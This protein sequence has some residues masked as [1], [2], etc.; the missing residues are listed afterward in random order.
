[1]TIQAKTKILK[2]GTCA[3]YTY[4]DHLTNGWYDLIRGSWRSKRVWCCSDCCRIITL[5][6]DQKIEDYV[7]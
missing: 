2:D 3:T 7:H 5:K 4:C 1:M 6:K